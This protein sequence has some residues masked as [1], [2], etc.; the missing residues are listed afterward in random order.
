MSPGLSI[1]TL[2]F[3]I[4]SFDPLFSDI[5]KCINNRLKLNNQCYVNANTVLVSNNNP[6]LQGTPKKTEE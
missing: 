5:H 3:D 2:K 1:G 6:P 4:E